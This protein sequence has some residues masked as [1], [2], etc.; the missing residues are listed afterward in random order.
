MPR[1]RIRGQ[2][3]T[4]MTAI[5]PPRE[6]SPQPSSV[7]EDGDGD[8]VMSTSRPPSMALMPLASAAT[9]P[10]SPPSL[11]DILSN[12]A[13]P[14]Y[15]LSAF[16]AFLSQNHCLETLEFTMD[17]DRYRLA[18]T[19][20]LREQSTWAGDA[21][22]HVCSLWQKLMHAY[23]LP[24][25][26]REVNL[27]AHV[28]D[29]LLS[30]PATPMPPQP[31]ELDDAVTIVYELMNDSVL[32]PFLAS[33]APEPDMPE[34]HMH[35][36]RQ[37]RT[38]LRIPKDPLSLSSADE[39]SRSPKI[40]F[41]PLLNIAWT[42]DYTSRSGSASGEPVERE[43]ALSDD[44]GSTGSPSGNEPMTPPT[45]PPTSD[46]GFSTSP[47]SLHRAISA[48][49]S[50]WK[51][52]G[53]K[54]GLSR[55]GRNK[56]AH[57]T[58]TTS[59]GSDHDISMNDSVSEKT[60]ALRLAV[61]MHEMN[62]WEEPHPG[63]RFSFPLAGNASGSAGDQVMGLYKIGM[64]A[65]GY[66][67]Y[68]N[69]GRTPGPRRLNRPRLRGGAPLKPLRVTTNFQLSVSAHTPQSN[70]SSDTPILKSSSNKGPTAE[71][72][73]KPLEV[74]PAY[75][76]AENR[77]QRPVSCAIETLASSELSS[78]RLSMT[79]FSNHLNIAFGGGKFD[80]GEVKC[81]SPMAYERVTSNEDPYGWE[82]ELNRKFVASDFCPSAY[83]Y[84]RA[85]GAKR[86]LLHRVFSLGPRSAMP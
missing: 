69:R 83:Q 45:T 34:E 35:D 20:I 48:H 75:V 67:P 12:T 17:A 7:F 78:P 49:S 72:C 32:G 73:S 66:T 26:P 57:N 55:K 37:A 51:K 9:S 13:P 77:I 58:S 70:S 3:P 23:I 47:G 18:H 85:G 29:R 25:G 5:P 63:K 65:K 39:S 30:L 68:P 16:M 42:N 62:D 60:Q 80:S 52:M 44:T 41:L 74:D 43:G 33:V 59:V 8:S 79:D 22:E 76:D 1:S 36:S 86:S 19:D 27:P 4:L 81:V 38:R 2:S 28:R 46:W 10:T 11:R 15:T 31:D 54:L 82:V 24:C 40:G 50:G 71:Y 64:A 61:T 6:T 53:A 21:N 14:P 56:R 84:R